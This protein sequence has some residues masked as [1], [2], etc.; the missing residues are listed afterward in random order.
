MQLENYTVI[1]IFSFPDL[2]AQNGMIRGVV[3][4]ESTGEPLISVTVVAEGTAK[5]ILTDLERKFNFQYLR[6]LII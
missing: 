3:L 6:G 1:F 5:G 4:D 2:W